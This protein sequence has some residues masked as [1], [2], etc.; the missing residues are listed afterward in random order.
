MTN[1]HLTFNMS[2]FL[3]ISLKPAVF[4]ISV[5]FNFILSAAQAK[6][7]GAFMTHYL[8]S[9]H[10]L[11]QQF[12]LALSSTYIQNLTTSHP[13]TANTQIQSIII[14]CLGYCNNLLTGFF[15]FTLV[16]FSIF[17]DVSKN[18]FVKTCQMLLPFSSKFSV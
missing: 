14:F 11:C 3:I 13:F 9:Y 18:Y 12:L 10:I 17:S 16:P 8:L 4:L 1:G 15:T 7:L 5:N 2:K 6:A